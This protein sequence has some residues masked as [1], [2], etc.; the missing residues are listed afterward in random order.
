[1]PKKLF[2]HVI[3]SIGFIGL[4]AG[5]TGAASASE[6]AGDKVPIMPL[7]CRNAAEVGTPEQLAACLEFEEA[8]SAATLP[9]MQECL[10]ENGVEFN[11]NAAFAELE[12]LAWEQL[13]I[14]TAMRANCLFGYDEITGEATA[15]GWGAV[16]DNQRA[17][18]DEF[19]AQATGPGPLGT[20]GLLTICLENGST[21]V[22]GSGPSTSRP[23]LDYCQNT[24]AR[25]AHEA[26]NS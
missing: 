26:A 23:G 25:L 15:P 17:E 2:R 20:K 8:R 10:T 12:I 24:L 11:P 22:F 6:A 5:C 16:P 21:A 13:A 19:W 18:W 4:L 7:N 3:V 14:P 9:L 1:M